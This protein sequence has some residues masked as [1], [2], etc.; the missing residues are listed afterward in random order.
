LAI[1]A[2]G[3]SPGEA[4][5]LR[6]AMAAWRRKGALETF[7]Q[8]LVDGMRAR[9]YSLDFAER[10]FHQ[11]KGFGEYGFPESHAAS[12]ALLVYASAW[13]K[14]HY[15]AA[16]LA[17]LLNSQPMGFYAPAQ[18]VADAQRHGVDVRPVDINAS[19]AECTLEAIADGRFAVR[20]GWNMVSGLSTAHAARIVRAR[21]DVPFRSVADVIQRTGIRSRSLS[22]LAQADAFHSLGVSRR[23]A[24]WHALARQTQ[25]PL[26]DALDDEPSVALP[27][28]SRAEEVIQ[29]Y[30]ACGLSLRDHPFRFLRPQLERRGV[31]PSAYLATCEVDRRYKVAG[32]VLLRQRPDTAKGITFMTLEDETGLTNLIVQQPVWERFHRI[33][34]RAVGIQVTGLLQRQEGVI[35]L[36]V[37]HMDD[38]TPLVAGIADRSRN[39]R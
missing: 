12:F 14:R 17:A 22:L 8:K 39:F 1:V 5:Q 37:D 35:H 4:D 33:A 28:L 18:L 16:F 25:L 21:G 29:D 26:F 13:L 19:G 2:A 3:F 23:E 30:R 24:L 32:L 7:H 27:A 36:L 20:L 34:R 31:I 6:R 38:L 9:G 10:L 11:I 15:P